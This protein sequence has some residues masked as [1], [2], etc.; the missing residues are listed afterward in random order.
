MTTKTAEKKEAKGYKNHQEGSRKGKVHS[1]YDRE[2]EDA[3]WTLG[4][5]LK[6]KEAS[7]RSWFGQWRRESAKK[8]RAA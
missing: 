7:L 4:R 1:L 5:K 2:G 3:A 8:K 6:L